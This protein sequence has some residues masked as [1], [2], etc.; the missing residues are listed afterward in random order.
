M[1]SRRMPWPAMIELIAIDLDGTLLDANHEI[2]PRVH[3]AIAAARARGV[4]VVL[5][6]GRPFSGAQRYLTELGLT[7]DEDHCISYNGTVV[8]VVATGACLLEFS[9]GYDDYRYCEQVACEL[10]VHFQAMDGDGIFTAHADISRYTVIDSYLSNAPLRYRAVADMDPALRFRKLMMIDAPQRLDAAIAQLPPQL[11]QRYGVF[12]SA[13]YYLEIVDARAGKGPMLAQLTKRLGIARERV[14]AIGDQE[15]DL[16]MLA[17]AGVSVA[18]G[19]AIPAVKTAAKHQT[20][21]NTEDGVA[22]AI[23]R[24]VLP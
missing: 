2:T 16:S 20:A 15:N 22:V 17:F 1:L 18:M 9:L 21:C 24:F 11:T 14:M 12:K 10:G 6:T 4:R 23:E 8:Q 19:N 3:D 13:P 5:A 7:G